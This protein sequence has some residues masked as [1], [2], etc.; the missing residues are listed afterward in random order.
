MRKKKVLLVEDDFDVRDA[1]QVLLKRQGHRVVCA[2]NGQEALDLLRSEPL[3]SLI[4]LDLMMPVMD[5]WRFREEQ[6]KD[7]ALAHI[8]VIV[9]SAAEHAETHAASIGAVGYLKK[10]FPLERLVEMVDGNE[11]AGAAGPDGPVACN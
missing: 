11:A 10:P 1:F 8:P 2:G 9:I 7:A 6:L 4:L 5:G 3:P